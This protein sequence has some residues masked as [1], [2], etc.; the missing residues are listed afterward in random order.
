MGTSAGGL[1]VRLGTP[2]RRGFMAGAAVA[3]VLLILAGCAGS[4]S[5]SMAPG[6]AVPITDLKTVAGKWAGVGSRQTSSREDWIDLT[7]RED[8]TFEMLSARQVGVL[9]ET[10]TLMVSNGTL[11]V[12]DGPGTFIYTLHDRG[13]QRVLMLDGTGASGVKYSAE[14]RPKP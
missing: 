14:L 8:G 11:R 6:V 3:L 12:K 2:G 5:S 10:G 4:G 13:G 7:I 9:K 1:A